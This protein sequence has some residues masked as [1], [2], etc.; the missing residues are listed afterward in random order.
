[1][2]A[3]IFRRHSAKVACR[4]LGKHGVVE[5]NYSG[6]LCLSAMA[7][8]RASVL[9]SHADAPAMLIRMDYS[10][11]LMTSIP[12][13]SHAAYSGSRTPGC[14][15]VRRD[16]FKIISAQALDLAK[17]GVRRIVFLDSQLDLALLWLERRAADRARPS[18]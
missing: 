17:H 3:H 11:L 9:S 2:Q 5:A 15:V 10:L 14:I 12:L 18:P 4:E 7:D 16:Q 6:P 1:M 8:L 13:D